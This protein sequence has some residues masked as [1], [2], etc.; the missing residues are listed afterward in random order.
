[1]TSHMGGVCSGAYRDRIMELFALSCLRT[2]L[3]SD[4]RP[5]GFDH[6]SGDDQ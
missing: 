5:S 1:M 2:K 3:A 6:G 4:L